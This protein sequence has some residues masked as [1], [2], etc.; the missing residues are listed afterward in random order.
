MDWK[1]GYRYNVWIAVAVVKNWTQVW[2]EGMGYC[3]WVRGME[4]LCIQDMER[5]YGYR[6]DVG[7]GKR[8]WGMERGYGVLKEGTGYGKRG[9]GMEMLW[10]Q[11]M[12]MG[13]GLRFMDTVCIKEMELGYGYPVDVWIQNWDL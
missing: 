9:R 1:K 2:K 3:K 10:I 6:V 7:Y 11:D 13:K 4:M 8:V 5:G 12:G